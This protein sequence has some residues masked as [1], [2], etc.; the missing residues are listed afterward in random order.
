MAIPAS[1]RAADAVIAVSEWERKE[2]LRHFEI[3]P[4]K[5]FTVYHGVSNVVRAGPLKESVTRGERVPYVVMVSTLYSYKNHRRLIE[6]F[7]EVVRNHDVPHELW[8]AGGAAD[9]SLSDLAQIARAEGVARRVR[10]LG[11]VAHSQVPQLLSKADAIAYPSLFE[12]FG[13]PIVEALSYGRP[14][15]TSNVTSM[16]EIAGDAA[17]LVDPYDVASIVTGLRRV[18]QDEPL[19]TRLAQDGPKRAASYTW[20]RSA[21]GTMSALRFAV[22]SRN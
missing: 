4:D 18:L 22:E 9:V 1:L 6:A 13:L 17:V 2:A 12:T 5:I 20:A 11:A 19:R 8:I 14:L 10:F 16:P 21:E 7:A 15:V 3:D